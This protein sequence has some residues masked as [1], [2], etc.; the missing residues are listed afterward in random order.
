MYPLLPS[1]L[2]FDATHDISAALPATYNW[3]LVVLSVIIA[4]LAAYAALGGAGRISAAKTPVAEWSWLATGAVAM[5]IGIWAM[6]FIGM[7]AF[8][9]PVAVGYDLLITLTSMVPAILASGLV[10]HVIGREHIGLSRLVLGG[11]LMGAGIGLMHY[12]GM[13]AMRMD[14]V[15]AYDPVIFIVS[16]LVAVALS[17]VALYAKFL[18][19]DN[20]QSLVH[21]AQWGTAVVMGLAVSGMHYTGMAAA[22]FFPGSGSHKA[23]ETLDPMWLG[24]WVGLATVIIVGIAILVIVV[25]RRLEAARHYSENLERVVAERTNQLAAANVQITSLNQELQADNLRMGAELDVTRRLQNMILPGIEELRRIE[26]LDIACHMQAADE[27]GGDYYDVLQHD[28]RVKIGIGDVTGHGLESGVVMVM[29]Q[30][31]VRALMTV[32]ESD[33]VRFLTALNHVI[34]GN[35][36]RMGSDKNLTLCLLDYA[37]GVMKVS[38][39]HEEMIVVRHDGALERVDT[40]DLGFP[41]GLDAEIAGFIDQKS[42]RLRPGDGVV[43]YTDGITE[44]ES[45]SNAQYG[46]E[47]LCDLVR[48]QWKNSAE[49]IKDA[50]VSD[51]AKFIGTQTIHDDITLVVVKK[52]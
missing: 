23:G 41:I 22:Y 9:L 35:M 3:A 42:V 40:I 36:Q 48:K 32:G 29:T 4:S 33:P 15:M 16:I 5:G 24:A 7:L 38:G 21:W 39:Q 19:I 10:L 44:A 1:F 37:D 20:T 8:T 52:A 17:I 50:V 6:H 46:L 28:G 11:V 51:V 12:T 43:L 49:M 30:A 18:V 45:P 14:A 2:G 13:A 25:D 31:I 34:Y 47:R 27:V 26:D